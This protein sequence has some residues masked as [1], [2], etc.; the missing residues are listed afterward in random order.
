LFL[1]GGIGIYS[2]VWAFFN[3]LIIFPW[4]D[5]THDN[6]D[7]SVAAS[8]FGVPASLVCFVLIALTMSQ[9]MTR[10]LPVY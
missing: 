3:V 10:D 6:G 1:L 9:I 8:W 4:K 7:H 2:L 5:D